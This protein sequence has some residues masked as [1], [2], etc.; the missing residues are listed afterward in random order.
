MK[1]KKN[2]VYLIPAIILC[3][4]VAFLIYTGSLASHQTT[5][6][7]VLAQE[8][9]TSEYTAEIPPLRYVFEPFVGFTLAIANNV[10]DALVLLVLAYAIIRVVYLVLERLVLRGNKKIKVFAAYARTFMNFYWKYCILAFLISILVLLV[11]VAAQGELFFHYNFM[12]AVQASIIAWLVLLVLK[13]VNNAVIFFKPTARLRVKKLKTWEALPRQ[14]SRY[15]N[16][17]TWDVIGRETRYGLSVVLL[18]GMLCLNMS[19]TQ[20]PTQLIHAQLAENEILIDL[21]VHTTMSDGWLTPEERVDWYLS[22]GIH[23]AAFADHFNT[24]GASRARDYVRAFNLDFTV[25]TAQEFTCNVPEIHLNVYGIE[26]NLSPIEYQGQPYSPNCMNVS[27]MIQYVKGHGG[28]VTVNH[29]EPPGSGPFNYTQLMN[30]GVDGFEIVNMGRERSPAIR[31]FCK[32]NNLTCLAGSDEHGNSP[33]DSFMRITLADPA[34]VTVDSIFAA[35]KNNTHEVVL[36]RFTPNKV[37]LPRSLQDFG[38]VESFLNYVLT[39]DPLEVTSWICWSCGIF[40][41][42]LFAMHRI[43]TLFCTEAQERKFVEDP[44][45]R[46][47]LFMHPVVA[48]IIIAASC[49]AALLLMLPLAPR[50]ALLD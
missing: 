37:H 8:D 19:S 3:I 41:A 17:K 43:K 15:R 7:D 26:E 22:Q 46:S 23:A 20:V 12:A 9:V 2:I 34:N 27:D 39:L 49:I 30:W 45:K 48:I 14:S 38:V 6:Y 25:I 5:F 40:C 50:L 36:V 29:Y 16:H 11:G 21:H 18:F 10:T 35:L 28:Y 33:L 32:A 4:W 44:K 1:L 13:L 31:Q 47:F 24:R 42:F